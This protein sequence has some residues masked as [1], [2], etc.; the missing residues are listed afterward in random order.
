MNWTK[1][2]LI[3]GALCLNNMAASV[4][5]GQTS[6][7]VAPVAGRTIVDGSV[8]DAQT[9]TPVMG[10]TILAK[11]EDGIV[12]DQKVTNANGDYSLTLDSRKSY[13]FTVRATGYITLDEQVMFTSEKAYQLK[14]KPTLLFRQSASSVQKIIAPS[15]PAPGTPEVAST[16]APRAAPP[17]TPQA[18]SQSMASSGSSSDNARVVPPKTLDAK[19]IYTPPLVVAPVGKATQLQALQFVQSQPDLLPDAQPAL[20]QLLGFMRD[21]PT[22]EIELAGH[23]DNQGDFDKNLQ[24][25]KQRVEV[26]KAYLVKNGIDANRITTRGYGPTRPIASNNREAT[27]QL[28]RR[29]EM[30]VVKQ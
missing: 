7:Q 15:S 16:P 29:V 14:R 17:A 10:A 28:N 21:H 26:V 27:R 9:K 23:T 12:R 20:D 6:Q 4:V 22:A 3:G 19:V 24:L 2:V 8:Q 30:T 1:Y 11:S 18:P 13:I 5:S 25:S